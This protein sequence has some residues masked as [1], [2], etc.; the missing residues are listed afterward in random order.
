MNEGATS[1]EPARITHGWAEANGIR[2]HYVRAGPSSALPL[3]L[4]HGFPESWLMWRLVLP[5]LAARY[6]VIAPDL[7]GYGDSAKPARSASDDTGGDTAYD[8]S[9]DKR[10]MAADV[11]A[12]LAQLDVSRPLLIGHD[13][14]AR[15]AR[16]YALDFAGDV[17]GVALLDILPAE[18]IYDRLSAAEVARR[19]WHWIFHLVPELPEQLIAG[20]EAAYL[21]RF[22]ARSPDLL[23]SL[24]ADGAWQ[25]YLRAFQQ[26]GAV[27]AALDD[28]RATFAVDV[29]RYRTEHAAGNRVCAPV[30]LLWG[31]DGNLGDLAGESVLAIWREVAEDVR[32]A[33]I[34]D[35][36]HY[37][38]EE[39][40]AVV[41]AHL[42]DFA[43]ACFANESPAN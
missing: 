7:R 13:R 24:R 30:L 11:H 35:C 37:L 17:V 39:Q 20:R 5:D 29:P 33:A 2:Q 10:T 6:Q 12:L 31:N 14:G 32:G 18:W 23:D 43:A 38:P 19:Y 4:L 26:P 1:P 3:V 41:A 22:F 27:A 8:G 15:V 28:Y 21:A 25:A 42:L 40:P 34:A 9:Y 16:R 36:G